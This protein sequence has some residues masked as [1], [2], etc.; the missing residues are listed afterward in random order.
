MNILRR[1][2]AADEKAGRF[3]AFFGLFFVEVYGG[4]RW[5]TGIWFV[6]TGKSLM[7]EQ[8]RTTEL[9]GFPTESSQIPTESVFPSAARFEPLYLSIYL[10]KKRE[11]S[12]EKA[13]KWSHGVGSNSHGFSQLYSFCSTEL[14]P[15][16][17]LF[18]GNPWDCFLIVINK[19]RLF[20]GVSHGITPRNARGG[21]E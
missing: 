1:T 13:E 12:R 11:E 20:R 7:L 14:D 2:K 5:N 9:A 17:G 19:V 16:H 10:S 21:S 18:R 8:N 15:S 6:F 4:V 3:G